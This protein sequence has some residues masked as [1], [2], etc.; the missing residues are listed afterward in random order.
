MADLK[1][2]GVVESNTVLTGLFTTT[3]G[4]ALA[5]GD[6]VLLVGQTAPTQNGVWV[7]DAG[8]WTRPT[9]GIDYR[10]GFEVR[11]LEGA[12]HELS[13]WLQTNSTAIIVDTTPMFWQKESIGE[14]Y[15][16]GSGVVIE[17]SSITLA[18]SGAI[19]GDYAQPNVQVNSFGQI[20]DISSGDTSASY[21]EDLAINFVSSSRISVGPGAAYIP[22]NNRIVRLTQGLELQIPIQAPT[23]LN[24]VYLYETNGVGQI[25]LS[26]QAPLNPYSGSAYHKEG[27]QSRRYLGMFKA[28]VNSFLLPSQ[29]F[30]LASNLY[31]HLYLRGDGDASLKF[32]DTTATADSVGTAV[33]ADFGNTATNDKKLVPPNA[34]QAFVFWETTGTSPKYI[35]TYG[36]PS[37]PPLKLPASGFGQAWIDIGLGASRCYYQMDTVGDTLKLYVSGYMGRR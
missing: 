18:P 1:V 30:F 19:P 31:K 20:S 6:Y 22:A 23:G 8:G 11:V 33:A 27:D 10:K 17:G 2:K 5:A 21:I 32:L 15:S 34:V 14:A 7:V 37:R 13:L 9:E 25:E 35:G 28:D 3:D 36:W 4:V 16:S 24:F 12:N 26:S 29:V